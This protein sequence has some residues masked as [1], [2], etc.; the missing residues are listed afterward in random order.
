ML[1]SP[2]NLSKNSVYLGHA[3]VGAVRSAAV[4]AE[5]SADPVRSTTGRS[6]GYSVAH[7][8]RTANEDGAFYIECPHYI[9]ICM[10]SRLI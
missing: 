9:D 7:Q 1:T 8:R 5:H 2:K 4:P 6:G 3:I 10:V